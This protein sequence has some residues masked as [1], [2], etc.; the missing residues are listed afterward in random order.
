ML[1]ESAK[2]NRKIRGAIIQVDTIVADALLAVFSGKVV[3]TSVERAAGYFYLGSQLN[4]GV[5]PCS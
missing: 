4:E 2:R 5:S 3:A 1:P